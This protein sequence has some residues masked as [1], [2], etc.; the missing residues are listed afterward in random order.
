MILEYPITD[1]II[2]SVASISEK[3]GRIKEIR[4]VHK[5]IDFD[6]KCNVKNVQDIF[7]LRNISYSEEA[8]MDTLSHKLP[9]KI[10][11]ENLRFKEIN[12]II[13]VY[14]NIKKYKPND[15]NAFFKIANILSYYELEKDELE[16]AIN[17]LRN[18]K[19]AFVLRLAEF[20]H[21]LYGY[22]PD[23][24]LIQVW[25]IVLFYN[26]LGSILYLP[27]ASLIE[28]EYSIDKL[29][30]Y[31]NDALADKCKKVNSLYPFI[32]FYLSVIDSILTHSIE[33]DYN[34]SNPIS[35]RVEILKGKIQEPFSRKDYMKYYN[36]STAT[37]S[38]D[39]RKAVDKGILIIDGD[40]RNARYLYK[41]NSHTEFL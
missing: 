18:Q 15:L 7:N 4:N 40:K 21:Q 36:I 6:M 16:T 23:N 33:T 26:E 11:F 5:H 35:G 41:D 28:R 29:G 9:V 17:T 14:A 37:A 12:K 25:L 30:E 19:K 10:N 2:S 24:D 13:G 3:I 20:C 8:I 38:L 39:L 32:E 27:Y 1:R 31:Y 22:T 34:L